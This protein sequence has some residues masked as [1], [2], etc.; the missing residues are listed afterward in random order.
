MQGS[1]KRG[2]LQRGEA[3]EFLARTRHG[4]DM[5]RAPHRQTN[6]PKAHAERSASSVTRRWRETGGIGVMD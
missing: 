6:K 3:R 1:P 4:I 2:R 5:E